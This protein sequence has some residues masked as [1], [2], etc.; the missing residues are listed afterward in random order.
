MTAPLQ[1]RFVMSAISAGQ[2]PAARADVAV[3]GRSNVGKSSLINAL[4]H[5]RELAKV[6][7][8]PGRT[9]ALNVFEMVRGDGI[10]VDL[11]GYGYAA[12]SKQTKAGWPAMVTDYLTKRESLVMI[13]ALV[14]G[15]IGPTKLD[16]ELL[17]WLRSLGLPF[18]VV[19]T[20][21]D[22]VK[23]QARLTRRRDLAAGCGVGVDEVRWV[24]AE[25]GTG[26]DELRS[27]VSGW[28]GG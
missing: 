21:S 18:T 23:S 10:L 5:R 2:L 19:A 8:T 16:V 15:E 22:K 26:V 1:L 11:P 24:S 27:A 25:R 17:A 6:S 7:K 4:A 20:K 14:D 28:L 12:V 13:L 3:V 9:R